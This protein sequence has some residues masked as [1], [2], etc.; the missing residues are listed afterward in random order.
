MKIQVTRLFAVAFAACFALL[1]FTAAPA[2][3]V[4]SRLNP[5]DFQDL[6]RVLVLDG[7]NVHNAGE[8][9]MHVGNWGLFG[10]FPGGTFPFS[11][12]PSAEWPAGS[13]VEYLYG[14]GLWVGAVVNGVPRVSTT[15]FEMEFRPTDDPVDMLYR[16]AE[17][18]SGGGRLPSPFA[19]DDGDGWVDEDWLN[20]RDDDGDGLID[21]DFAAIST[22]MFSCWYTDDQPGASQ[23]YPEHEPMHLLV[24]QESYQ[25][26]DDRFDDFVGIDFKIT[27]VGN[28]LLEDVYLGFLIDLDIGPRDRPLYWED[29]VTE[30]MYKT[31]FCTDLGPA[32]LEMPYSHDGDGDGGLAPGYLGILVLDHTTDP[33]GVNAPRQAGISAYADF[34]GS[35][36]FEEGGDPTNDFERY[37]LISQEHIDRPS[38]A[39]RDYRQL[40]AVGPF[41]RLAPG[42]TLTFTLA[43]VLGEGL[44]GLVQNAASARIL[45]EGTWFD[46]D[47]SS[48]TGI[49]RRETPVYGPASGVAIDACR[50]GLDDPIDIPAGET[51]WIN[52][53]CE[54]E[55]LFKTS[56]GYAEADSNEFRTG[57][58][59]KETQVHWL[60]GPGIIEAAM[61]IRPG[62]CPNPFDMNVCRKGPKKDKD[63]M[64]SGALKVALLGG[65]DFD[66][67]KIDLESLNLEGARPLRHKFRDTGGPPDDEEECACPS[68][69]P[70]GYKDLVLWFR[71]SDV[72]EAL[73]DVSHG[74]VVS[75]TLTG[76]LS[77]GSVFVATDCV[78]IIDKFHG[79]PRKMSAPGEEVTLGPAVPNPFN[80][81]TRIRYYLP[82]ETYVTLT[83]YDVNGKRVERLVEG[84]QAGGEH[85]VDWNAGGRAS[86]VYFYRLQAGD[87]VRVERMILLK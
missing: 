75:L 86:G 9:H 54:L 1:S 11:G 52:S 28:D 72:A 81:A 48:L 17:G 25:W 85:A 15:M 78:K 6:K 19:D 84:V 38:L 55:R 80:P 69:E 42:E 47:R 18:A 83:V 61:D 87:V 68:Q 63:S 41:R 5:K 36:P 12:A 45:Y 51:V 66:V 71:K 10:S 79:G 30:F 67:T 76:R 13:G 39:A 8:L 56:C 14:A 60:F 64:I 43:I 62:V 3:R 34:S 49:D 82:E 59:G 16:G 4:D 50:P 24:R 27:N 31:I 2:R 29:D 33:T 21:E 35:Q 57:V 58:G 23:L 73:G 77:D 65:P 44:E 53:D 32:E 74:D 22:Q 37:E 20:G 26:A 7:S 46:I 70:D 40:I